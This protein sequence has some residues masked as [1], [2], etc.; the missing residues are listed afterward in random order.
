MASEKNMFIVILLGNTKVM[1][2]KE[3]LVIS[4]SFVIQN[5]LTLLKELYNE[6]FAKLLQIFIAI[7][8][9]R[10]SNQLLCYKTK[11]MIT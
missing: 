10:V 2:L 8:S 6:N 11:I 5:F 4:V 1:H 7:Y 3:K 9:T